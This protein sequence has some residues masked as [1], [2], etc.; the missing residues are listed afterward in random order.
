MDASSLDRAGPWAFADLV[1]LPDDG[2]R[3]EVVD[4]LL[5][6]RPPPSQAHQLLSNRL[7]QQLGEQAPPGWEVV[8]E[9]AL[10]LGTDGRVP[11]VSVLH[12]PRLPPAG[13]GPYPYGAEH[14]ALV[15]EIVSPA[16]RKTDRFSKPGEYAEA[17]IALLW[18]VETDPDIVLLAFRLTG[19]VYAPA[20]EVRGRGWLPVPWGFAEIDVPRLAALAKSGERTPAP[21]GSAQVRAQAW[22]RQQGMTVSRTGRVPRPAM[23]EYEAAH[24]Q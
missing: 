7:R 22:A 8:V 17:G 23:V 9:F 20:G 3:Y 11:D 1:E 19:E 2:R 15:V 13:A 4:G 16:S 5:V 18:R 14:F 24:Q 10:P 12:M 21:P 6:V